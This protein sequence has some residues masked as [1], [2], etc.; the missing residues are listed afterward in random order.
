[1]RTVGGPSATWGNLRW[2][3]TYVGK[4]DILSNLLN[5]VNINFDCFI[6][7]IAKT[8]SFWKEQRSTEKEMEGQH[9]GRHDEILTD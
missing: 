3:A 1:M 6:R 5:S 8:R 2:T 7:E 4:V 9:K